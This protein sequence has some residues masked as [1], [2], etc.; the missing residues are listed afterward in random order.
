[1]LS[2]IYSM[3]L[4]AISLCVM[5]I[6]DLKLL[7]TVVWSDLHVPVDTAQYEA[8]LILLGKRSLP[9]ASFSGQKS[10][11]ADKA[12]FL[13]LAEIQFKKQFPTLMLSH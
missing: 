4:F 12:S 13:K 9:F 7:T 11:P 1:M 5:I 6:F 2:F 3:P 8:L 10:W